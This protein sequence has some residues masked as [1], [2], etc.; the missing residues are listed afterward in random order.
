MQ[1]SYEATILKTEVGT[2]RDF[3]D[4]VYIDKFEN[5]DRKVLN[6]SA[7]FDGNQISGFY[8]I[9]KLQ[10]WVKSNL[11]KLVEKNSLPEDTKEWKGLKIRV[12]IDKKGYG[13]FEL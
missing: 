6:V 4:K 8:T 9:P 2:I 1:P 10:G 13:K 5:P 11:K 12:V 7:D 3:V